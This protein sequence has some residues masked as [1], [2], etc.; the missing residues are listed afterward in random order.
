MDA[1]PINIIS[2]CSGA[3]GLDLGVRLAIPTAR[4]VCWVEWEAYA[5]GLLAERMAQG[6]VDEAPVWSNLRTFDG[7]PWCGLVDGIV[8]GYP[9]QPFSVAGKRS[10]ADD[11]RHLWPHVRRVFEESGA[12][13]LFCEN[14]DGHL[15]MGFGDV[16]EELHGLGCRVVPAVVSA[17]DVAFPHRRRRLFFLAYRASG[18]LGIR[19]ESPDGDGLA[20][21]RDAAVDD[22][23]RYG[24][25]GRER[26]AGSGRGVC[27]TGDAMDDTKC[28]KSRP[29]TEVEQT[30]P[31]QWRGGPPDANHELADSG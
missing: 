19:G 9:C 5:A 25:H 11:H 20:D 13:F 26:E 2:L 21:R 6:V 12:W 22:A 4:V 24:G 15:S 14:V 18:G 3:G 10:G 31:G 16:E 7:R 8:A 23:A 28:P 17:S 30:E 29:G 27:E 1:R